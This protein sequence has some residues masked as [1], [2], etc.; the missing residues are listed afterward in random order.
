MRA[1]LSWLEEQ[2]DAESAR[3][4]IAYV[5]TPADSLHARGLDGLCL[6]WCD[7]ALRV[8]GRVGRALGG[9][10]LNRDD[11]RSALRAL[12]EAE[13][14]LSAHAG[15][16]GLAAA[17]SEQAADRLNRGDLEQ[18]PSLYLAVDRMRREA[19]AAES[20]DHR[21]SCS[22]W[23]TG[24]SGDTGGWPLTCGSCWRKA[25]GPGRNRPRPWRRITWRGWN[26]TA[27]VGTSRGT[28]AGEPWDSIR[29]SETT[30][31]SRTCWS[32]GDAALEG[33]PSPRSSAPARPTHHRA[34]RGFQPRDFRRAFATPAPAM[35]SRLS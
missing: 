2:E 16:E 10:Q 3:W 28:G 1:S 17:R 11:Y 9:L 7:S 15:V 18:A 22:G 26:S 32:S 4:L 13:R 34:R 19:G 27:G 12:D 14:L 5:D 31:A 25:S 30:A 6:R 21:C 24:N 8:C 33:R 29:T 23:C 20:S 35:E